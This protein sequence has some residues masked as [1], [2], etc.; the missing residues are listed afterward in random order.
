VSEAEAL[1]RRRW[2]AD[3]AR[4]YVG[5]MVVFGVGYIAAWD[6]EPRER[7]IREARADLEWIAWF[8]YGTAA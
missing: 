2:A 5:M 8:Q 4:A 3:W 7:M 6:D 1:A